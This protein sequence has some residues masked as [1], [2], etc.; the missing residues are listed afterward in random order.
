[1]RKRHL[2]RSQKKLDHAIERYRQLVRHKASSAYLREHWQ[3][4]GL[5]NHEEYVQAERL[6]RAWALLSPETA[7]GSPE[8]A[9]AAL[10]WKEE[11]P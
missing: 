9:E 3:A 10:R 7:L 8:D 1:M 11:K 5:V 6:R 2:T 4:Q